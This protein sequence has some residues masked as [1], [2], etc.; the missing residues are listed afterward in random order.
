MNISLHFQNDRFMVTFL[1]FF[2][3][4]FVGHFFEKKHMFEHVHRQIPKRQQQPRQYYPEKCDDPVAER[5]ADWGVVGS[6][7]EAKK[8]FPHDG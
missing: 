3:V 4:F 6:R 5:W 2:F 7:I 8:K 1:A